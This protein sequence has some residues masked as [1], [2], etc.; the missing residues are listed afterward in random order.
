MV[1]KIIKN[2]FMIEQ[3]FSKFKDRV[4][5]N[6]III[7]DHE[8]MKGDENEVILKDF[9]EYFIPP[10][11]TIEQNKKLIDQNGNVSAQ[12]DLILWNSQEMPRIFSENDKFFHCECISM[13]FEVK[14]TLNK[15]TLKDSIIKAYKVKKLK[16]TEIIPRRSLRNDYSVGYEELEKI[17]P[18]TFIIFAYR[19]EWKS[20]KTITDNIKDL[21]NELNIN[22]KDVFDFIYILQPGIT[23]SW[24]DPELQK[25]RLENDGGFSHPSHPMF[26]PFMGN[27]GI[28]EYMTLSINQIS[29][30]GKRKKNFEVI[31]LDTEH[32]IKGFLNFTIKLSQILFEEVKKPQYSILYSMWNYHNGM[33]SSSGHVSTIWGDV[34]KKHG[35]Y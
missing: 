31:S 35:K 17:Y 14:T 27:G 28:R 18:P 32:Q 1:E 2:N 11:Y 10:K 24:N 12:T 26:L 4:K 13:C 22:F 9:L 21:V 16:Y 33:I 23:L 6:N 25:F 8:G 30:K 34:F 15:E 29:Q 7:D 19:T 5:A 3:M 20:M